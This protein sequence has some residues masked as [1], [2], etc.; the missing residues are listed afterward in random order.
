M[1]GGRFLGTLEAVLGHTEAVRAPPLHQN[2]HAPVCP[3]SKLSSLPPLRGC[4]LHFWYGTSRTLADPNKL[5][6]GLPVKK[7]GRRKPRGREGQVRGDLHQTP[8][9]GDAPLLCIFSG[10]LLYIIVYHYIMV[11]Y[12][13]LWHIMVSKPF[14]SAPQLEDAQEGHPKP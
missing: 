4:K 9:G 12:G 7:T 13:I 2:M 6:E 3:A 8:R 14:S 1:L 5:H 10:I 11:Y